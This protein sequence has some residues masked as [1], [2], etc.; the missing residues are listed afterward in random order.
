MDYTPPSLET[1]R[2]FFATKAEAKRYRKQIIQY[3]AELK[4]DADEIEAETQR[5]R[6]SFPKREPAVLGDDFIA[7][8]AYIRGCG[9]A[10]RRNRKRELKRLKSANHVP[11]YEVRR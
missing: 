7:R 1:L 6:D 5:I 11:S 4:R 8:W 10:V 3:L 9:T 2:P